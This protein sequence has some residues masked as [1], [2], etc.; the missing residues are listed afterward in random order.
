MGEMP[1]DELG[2]SAPD[3]NTF[4]VELEVCCPYFNS[5]ITMCSFCPCNEDF[6][7]SCNGSYATS[8][9]TMLSSGP[10]LVDSYEPMALQVH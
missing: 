6:Y 2:V 9:E 3:K 1:V 7:N 4:V 10:Y 5:L 8:D